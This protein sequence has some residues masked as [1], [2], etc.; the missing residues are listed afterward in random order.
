MNARR[1]ASAHDEPPP[2][3]RA[4][5]PSG[6]R[7]QLTLL[8]LATASGSVDALAFTA[9]GGVF[10]GV[11]TGNLVLGGVAAA[12]AA[13]PGHIWSA[14]CALGGYAV[15]TA[16]V[17]L[18]TR[19]ARSASSAEPGRLWPRRVRLAFGA[20]ALV[21]AVLAGCWIAAG[22]APAD[23]WQTLL[24][25]GYATAMGAQATALL[26]AGRSGAPTTY[27]TSTL[28]TL[29]A[30]LAT[31]TARSAGAHPSDLWIA[32]RLACLVAGAGGAVGLHAA[33]AAPAA[34]LP[35]GLVGA[36]GA[37]TVVGDRRNS[38]AHGRS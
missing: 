38:R 7:A 18:L 14:A 4:A 28:T 9:L 22:S 32:A 10:A 17:A 11:M 34:L 15:G 13:P 6:P 37:V 21:L 33:V 16:A 20:E 35:V 36:A 25:V 27:F 3:P 2:E 23:R 1:R 24:V 19:W 29:L 5:D 30:R 26:A 8:L 31:G 12:G